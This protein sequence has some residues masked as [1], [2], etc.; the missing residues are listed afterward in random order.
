MSDT[1][2]GDFFNSL[3][4]AVRQNPVSAALVGMGILWMFTGGNR[5]TAAAAILAP[6]ARAVGAGVGGGLQ[7]PADAVGTVTEGIRS[8]GSRVA[9]SVGDTLSSAGKSISDGASQAFDAVKDA[10]SSRAV[11]RYV[12]EQANAGNGLATAL[13]GNLKTTFERQPLLLGAI[14][15]AVG[16]GMA[17]GLPRTEIETE[18]AGEAADRVKAQVKEIASDQVD[19]VTETA[20]RTFEAVKDEAVAQGLT[21]Q[22]AKESAAAVGEK[23]KVVAQA[24]RGK[25]KTARKE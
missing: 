20:T 5:I 4:D 1:Q 19:R 22:A 12:N 7:A 18:F 21:G 23:L 10:S 6:S 9:D 11:S 13:Q 25:S 3:Q 16:A 24:A 14:G 2:S 8:V 17:A 15:L